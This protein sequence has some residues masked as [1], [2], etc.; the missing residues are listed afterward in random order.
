MLVLYQIKTTGR[1]VNIEDIEDTNEKGVESKGGD[2][3]E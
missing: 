1:T 2:G 3:T